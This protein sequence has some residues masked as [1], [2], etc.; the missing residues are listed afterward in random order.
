MSVTLPG[1]PVVFAGDEFALLGDDGEH[2]RSPLPWNELDDPQS[3]AS[4][5]VALYSQLIG[6]RREHSALSEGGI[7]WVHVDDDVLA[8][9]RESPDESILLIAA[10]APVDFTLDLEIGHALYGDLNTQRMDAATR[11]T[12][13][14]PSF[15]AWLLPP[16]R[17]PA[18]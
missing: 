15:G 1:I 10:R 4:E 17:V 3:L 12:T 9:L 14:G 6:L 8:Y 13:D 16:P 5:T 2:S 11:F 7:R 18:F